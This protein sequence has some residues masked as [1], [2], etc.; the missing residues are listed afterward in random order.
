[1]PFAKVKRG[2]AVLQIPDF[3][4]FPAD[5]A[6]HGPCIWQGHGVEVVMA[7]EETAKKPMSRVT[8]HSGNPPGQGPFM[9]IALY[10]VDGVIAEASYETYPCPGCVA[11]GK[12]I[13]ELATG[14][15]VDGARSITHPVL[16][17]RV[18]PLPRHRQICYGLAVLALNSALN[19]L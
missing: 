19:E 2:I 1:M 16:V 9:K 5:S 6:W 7:T 15:S 8:G 3:S 18:G 13:C 12:A 14:K 4:V 10:V 17:E 11:C